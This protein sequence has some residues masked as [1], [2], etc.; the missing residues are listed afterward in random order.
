MSSLT[1][2][3]LNQI[4]A[5]SAQMDLV[6]NQEKI[7]TK[8]SLE[9]WVSHLSQT[10]KWVFPISYFPFANIKSKLIGG[11]PK[12]SYDTFNS[13]HALAVLSA[14]LHIDL[15]IANPITIPISHRAVYLH[16]RTLESLDSSTGLILTR[17]PTEPIIAKAAMQILCKEV[18]WAVSLN[19]F[20]RNLLARNAIEKGTKRE[21][22]MRLIFTLAHDAL[23][24]ELK[25]NLYE[26]TLPNF[27]VHDFFGA[28][29]ARSHHESLCQIDSNIL[30]SHMNFVGFTSAQRCLREIDSKSF[31]HLCYSL[32]RRS[33]ALQLAPQEETFHQLIPF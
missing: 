18:N 1:P 28:L 23:M 31:K 7:E 14:H 19:T 3:D 33:M 29:F 10:S 21:L 17:T 8:A 13:D 20:T 25:F 27:T 5:V 22:F 26:S 32:L 6:I 9:N 12:K 16:M 24:C 4:S 15:N 11:N 2:Y 30:D